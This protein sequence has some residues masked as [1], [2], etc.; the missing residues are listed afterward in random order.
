[1]SSPALSGDGRAVVLG[2]NDGKL[3]ALRTDTGTELWDLR[4]GGKVSG[5][6]T[7]AGNRIYVTAANGGLWALATHD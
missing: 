6:P 2:A 5:S 4:I 3:Y 7:L 1:M